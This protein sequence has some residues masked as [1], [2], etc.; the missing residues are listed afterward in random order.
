MDVTCLGTALKNSVFVHLELAGWYVTDHFRDVAL[1]AL[2]YGPLDR[3]PN[4]TMFA[5]TINLS[6][7]FICIAIL[8]SVRRC[9]HTC[10]AIRYRSVLDHY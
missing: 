7:D 3:C 10:Y 2:L 5:H 8:F 6:P 9:L 4:C 1:H